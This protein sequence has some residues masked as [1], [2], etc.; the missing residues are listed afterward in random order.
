MDYHMVVTSTPEE[1]HVCQT[2]AFSLG[3]YKFH[4]K[5][6]VKEIFYFILPVESISGLST[7]RMNF[8][9]TDADP[10]SDLIKLLDF[11]RLK[12]KLGSP[13]DNAVYTTATV[14]LKEDACQTTSNKPL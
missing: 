13:S 4:V 5:H 11:M 9:Y 1:Q 12:A 10:S 14:F 2:S 8:E 3:T 6:V 7:T